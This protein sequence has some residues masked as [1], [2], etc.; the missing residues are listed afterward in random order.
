MSDE[1]EVLDDAMIDLG[2]D[3]L[4]FGDDALDLDLDDDLLVED[5]EM[6]MGEEFASSE[7]E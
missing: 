6:G 1:E 5:E 4:D 3:D 2:D 7:I